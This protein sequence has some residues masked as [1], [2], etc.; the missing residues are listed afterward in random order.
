MKGRPLRLRIGLRGAAPSDRCS[1]RIGSGWTEFT[2]SAPVRASGHGQVCEVL[3]EELGDWKY[4]GFLADGMVSLPLRLKEAKIETSRSDRTDRS[5]R[6]DQSDPSDPSL[7]SVEALTLPAP[8]FE[9]D[10]AASGSAVG[11]TDTWTCAMTNLTGREVHGELALSVRDWAGN[12]IGSASRHVTLGSGASRT[13][14]FRL[15]A[16]A[17]PC[18]LAEFIL[19]TDRREYGPTQAAITSPAEPVRQRA[20][21]PRWG[22]GTGLAFIPAGREK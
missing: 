12:P 17:E 7:I 9:I 11:G 14:H 6:S 13:E 5:D 4:E 22:M 8:A 18:R 16:P 15:P 3:L 19:R 20:R 21:T 10:L 1:I 2:R